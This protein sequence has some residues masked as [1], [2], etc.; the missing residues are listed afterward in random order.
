MNKMVTTKEIDQ[1]CTVEIVHGGWFYDL[2]WSEKDAMESEEI[3][4]SIHTQPLDE[5]N[6]P[7]GRVLHIGTRQLNHVLVLSDSCTDDDSDFRST[8]HVGVAQAATRAVTKNYERLTDEEWKKGGQG[9]TRTFS[10][11]VVSDPSAGRLFNEKC[12][13]NTAAQVT[14]DDDDSAGLSTLAT[15]AMMV[16]VVAVVH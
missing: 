4:T 12:K 1:V 14:T 10:A 16:A 2:Y 5:N 11:G 9:D 15:L 3:A 8:L 13:D 6:N 7:V